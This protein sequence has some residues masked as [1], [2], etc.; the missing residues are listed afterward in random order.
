[1]ADYG[2]MLGLKDPNHNMNIGMEIL[3]CKRIMAVSTKDIKQEAFR[4]V[5]SIRQYIYHKDQDNDDINQQLKMFADGNQ[6]IKSRKSKINAKASASE[7]INK[8]YTILM[9][10]NLLL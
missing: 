9:K 8:T 10:R 6:K 3:L 5:E 2:V 4:I 1:M 7:I